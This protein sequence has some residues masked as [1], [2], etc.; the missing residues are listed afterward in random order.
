MALK[1]LWKKTV[2]LLLVANM[3]FGLCACG[4]DKT[5]EEGKGKDGKDAQRVNSELAK[6][7]VYKEEG[8]D[9]SALGSENDYY[10]TRMQKSGDKLYVLASYNQYKTDG[11]SLSYFKLLSMNTDGSNSKVME[12]LLPGQVIEEIPEEE[13]T[14]EGAGDAVVLPMPRAEVSAKVMVEAEVAIENVVTEDVAVEDAIVEDAPMDGVFEPST[15]YEY[16]SYGQ[17]VISEEGAVYA[18]RNHTIEDWSDPE[19][20]ISKNDTTVCC[21]DK[22]G[23]FMWETP[24][25]G[26]QTE[27]QWYYVRN[28]LPAAEGGITLLVSGDK[29]CKMDVDK[30]GKVSELKPFSTD[31]DSTLNNA[32]NI[33]IGNDGKLVFTYYDQ[34]W[35]NLYMSTYDPKTDAVSEG[36]KLPAVLN[37]MGYSNMASGENGELV[38]SN[39]SGVF[40]FTPGQEE[41][42]QLMSYINS[43]LNVSDI[44]QMVYLDENHMIL[45]YYDNYDGNMHCGYFTK[46]DPKDIPDKDVIVLAG[47]WVDYNLKKRVVDYNKASDKYRIVVKEY[48]MY[49]TNE[50]YM[51]GYTRLNNDII[52]GN[53]PDIMIADNSLPIENYISK[54]ILADV[55]KLIA[56]DEELSK[57][58]FMENVF[59]AYKMDGK[60]YQVI[61]SFYVQTVIGKKSNVGD[62]KSWTMKEMREVA[63]SFGE[64]TQAFGEMTRDSFMYYVMN[65]GSSDFVDVANGKCNFNSQQFIDVLEYAKT[66][67]EQIDED[68][69]GDEDWWLTYQSQYRENRTLLM[70]LYIGD[71]Q[72]M[73]YQINGYMG[74]DVSYV[75]FPTDTGNGSVLGADTSYVLSAKSKCLDG[76]WDFVRYYLTDEYQIG[77]G[78]NVSYWGL[79]ISKKAFFEKAKDVTCK[80]YWIDENGEKQEYDDYFSINGEDVVIEPLSQAQYEEMVAFIQSVTKRSYY[81]EELQKIVTEGVEPFFAGQK[82]AADVAKII[83]SRAQVYV[84]ENM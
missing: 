37:M 77:D 65:F 80:S 81:N 52:A 16:S 22:D 15:S 8:L 79:P 40:K 58:E 53:I 68:Y 19:N 2:S 34:E 10:I 14:G 30:D 33:M 43:D 3:V 55:G 32:Q 54:G 17:S 26:L 38:F 9:L 44:N 63:E 5:N 35:A 75:G 41:P 49:S 67:P 84:N 45:T 11:T 60:L 69:Y 50:D 51:A 1:S 36:V 42:V 47:N 57:T 72:S 18:I 74:E 48:Q 64:G 23:N 61:P 4:G 12:L 28:I 7:F 13:I 6:Q 25:E 20:Y 59:E 83:Q 29:T 21:W 27:E 24:V 82:S 39:S 70:Y 56:E 71:F 76:A 46:V 66:L 78:Q 73:K 31:L 62:R